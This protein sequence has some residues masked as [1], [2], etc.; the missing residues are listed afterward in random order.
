MTVSPNGR[1]EGPDRQRALEVL[2]IEGHDLR[3]PLANIRSHASMI[4]ARRDGLDPR[5]RRAAEIIVKNADRG[6]R[7]ID[8]WMDF[9]RSSYARLELS[10]T[11]CPIPA[12]ARM[13]LADEQQDFD[14]K[15]VRVETEFDE[16]IPPVEIDPAR[17]RQAIAALLTAARRRAPEGSTIYL[18]TRRAGDRIRIEVEDNGPRPSREEA[19][20]FYDAEFQMLAHRRMEPGL[21]MALARAVAEAHGG[22]AGAEP[23]EGGAIHHLELP[24][25]T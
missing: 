9:L 3:S 25:S 21:E 2:R 17:V 5:I 18:R 24:L 4:L 10:R 1:A 15:G 22:K 13:A 11:T 16:S 23:V 14:Q 8:E 20:L 19:D 7:L 6:L 12:I